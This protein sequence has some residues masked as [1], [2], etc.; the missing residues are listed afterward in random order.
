LVDP[1]ADVSRTVS[2]FDAIRF[3]DGEEVDGTPID[4]V[5]LLEIDCEGSAFLIDRSTKDDH[6]VRCNPAADA[7]H[8]ETVLDQQSV[9]STRHVGCVFQFAQL[10]R[11]QFAKRPSLTI[12]SQQT[13]RHSQ[14]IENKPEAGSASTQWLA[15]LASLAKMANLAVLEGRVSGT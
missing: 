10:L 4:Q 8:R 9:D 14:S 15:N 2:E 7:Q 13:D 6:V 3:A 1:F 5:N 12:G 11:K